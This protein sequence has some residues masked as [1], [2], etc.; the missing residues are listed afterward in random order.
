MV[1]VNWSSHEA[2]NQIYKV[3]GH[4]STVTY[5]INKM[6]KESKNGENPE[7]C[8]TQNINKI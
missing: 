8:I 5:I 3:Y 1:R 7:L 2:C 6:K 4:N